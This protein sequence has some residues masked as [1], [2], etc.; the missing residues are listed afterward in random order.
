MQDIQAGDTDLIPG[1]GRSPGERK[2][3]HSSILNWKMSIHRVSKESDMTGWLNNSS[4]RSDAIWYFSSVWLTSLSMT[5]CRKCHYFI[6]FNGWVI[7]HCIYVPHFFIH[8]SVNGYCLT[9]CVLQSWLN[10]KKE[11]K[12]TCQC[13]RHIWS[14]DQEDPLKKRMAT[15]SKILA[16]KIPWTDKPGRLQSMGSQRVGNNWVTK[17]THC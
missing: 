5:C 4:S 6:I 10:G 17:P 12:S 2:A 1:L 8:S 7:F 14:L 13:R 3:T 9:A 15:H 16:W 11:K